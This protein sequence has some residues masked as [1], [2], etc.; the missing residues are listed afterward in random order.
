MHAIL[1]ENR[2]GKAAVRL[3]TVARGAGAAE[4]HTL[5]DLTVEVAFRG[6]FEAAHRGGDNSGV[7]PTDSMKNSVYIVARRE[8]VG[9]IEEFAGQL[10][11]HYLA[12]GTAPASVEIEISERPWDR[13]DVHGRPHPHAFVAPGGEAGERRIARL[14]AARDG[15]LSFAAG[16]RG[17][18]VLKTS[19]SAFSGFPRDETTTLRETR[20]RIFATTVEA[21]WSYGERPADFGA[22]FVGVRRELLETFATHRS[23]SVQQTM[24]AMGERALERVDE[25]DE[26]AL[27]LPNQHHLLVDLAPFGL[28]NPNAVFVATSEPFG[29]I[30]AVLKRS[31]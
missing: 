25:V 14:V 31:G 28:D 4:T 19:D 22:A 1:G 17:L 12:R 3:V 5:R 20:D 23:E 26:I 15:A 24:F 30:R 16:I 10:A 6:D 11:R 9:E 13:L 7:Y 29:D 2:Y 18:R 27:R 21:T 8:G